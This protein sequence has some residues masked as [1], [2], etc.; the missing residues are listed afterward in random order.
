MKDEAGEVPHGTAHAMGQASALPDGLSTAEAA[1]RLA[2]V[3]PNA[4]AEEH[5]HPLVELG[6]HFWAPV[7]WMLE[8][9]VVLQL[10]VGERLEAAMIIVLL[11]M[12]VGLSLFQESRASTTLALL[13][14]RLAPQVRVRRDG[15]WITRP[16]AD[17]VPGDIVQLSLGGI[18][19]ADLRLHSGSLLL[20]Q[21]MLTGESIPVE[22]GPE[23]A[24]YAGALVRRGEAVGEVTATG[25]RTYFGR[26]AELV[27]IAHVESSEQKAV[28]AV[29]RALTVVNFAIVVGIVAYAHV[30]GLTMPQIAPL[31]LTAMLSAVPVALPATFTLAAALGAK[32]LAQRGVLLT[33]LTALQEA[34]MIDVL[35]VDK[36][37]TL[38]RNELV[39]T[40]IHP[41]DDRYD[42]D[43]VLAYAAAASSLEGQDPID[44]VIRSQAM[45][46]RGEA[47][48]ALAVTQFTP[49][50]PVTKMAEAAVIDESGRQ[51][52]VIKGSPAAVCAAAPMT[53]AATAA[54]ASSTAAGHRTL[55]IAA[56]PP[57]AVTVIGLIAFGDPPRADSAGL[58]ADLHT[59]GVATIM[60]TGDTA[61][62]A[63]TV[64][65]AI[66]LNGP[67]CPPG[68]IPDSVEPD[69]FAVYAGVFP[70]DKFRLVKA[71]QRSGHAVGMCGDGANDA[72]ALRQAQM[73]IAVSTATD[74]AKA[75]A[76]IV[77]TEPGLAGIVT[78]IKEGRAAFQ[79]VLTYTLSI[80]INKCATLIVM[81]I[82]LVM[83]HHAV[84][85]PLLQ[86]L[87]MLAADF[88]T[89][90][91][92]ADR[93]RPTAYPNTW[94][95]RNM[96]VAAIPLGLFKLSYYVLLLAGG[97][98]L[99]HLGA[100]DMR[101][102]TFL[103]LALA[104]QASIYV[105]RERRH[106]WTSWP[107]A[108]M[109]AATSLDLLIVTG[110]AAGGI[111]MSRLPGVAIGAVWLATLCFMVGFDQIKM[112]VLNWIR[113]D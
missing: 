109:L 70:E 53:P 48:P 33:R 83:T 82:G 55:V 32:T 28:M 95:V 108:V 52:R 66:G 72:P 71:L 17:L 110:L 113:I 104:G 77:L 86:A 7:P 87:M 67:V 47:G 106:F 46:R 94:R 2:T 103:M 81:G 6:R 29:V 74:V 100:R 12:N 96:V 76:G 79:R 51:L 75:A 69:R 58:L 80:L 10:A 15:A 14:Q 49:F 85:T 24:A 56:G 98:Y 26:T 36:T 73:G 101:T 16:A 59:L 21:S 19:P 111:L 78:A 93:A 30:I 20:D 97:W 107:A 45:E 9:T 62:T 92:A 41:V 22:L 44:T 91:R 37:G 18:V 40:T 3:G 11:L 65:G 102:L 64:A 105:L 60:V 43:A 5:R 13:K 63:A 8:A 34:A 27:G 39:I 25:R 99:L 23:Q 61:E 35:C 90:S 112:S 84:L 31:V 68:G 54:L 88:V 1:Q 57:D 38:T 50:D 89:M 4:V 42:G